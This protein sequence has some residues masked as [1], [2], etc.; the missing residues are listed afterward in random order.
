MLKNIRLAATAHF[1]C[2]LK[3]FRMIDGRGMVMG[4]EKV[5]YF[6]TR[7]GKKIITNPSANKFGDS[8]T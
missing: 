5:Y 4:C 7:R 2:Q 6:V 8:K 1:I 3:S